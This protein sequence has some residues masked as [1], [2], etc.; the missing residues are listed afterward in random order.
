M[1]KIR[2]RE[3]RLPSENQKRALGELIQYAFVEIR[4]IGSEGKG[5]QASDLADIFHNVSR[6]MFGWG[7]WN[8]DIF[9]GMLQDYQDKYHGESYFGK[10]DY[11]MRFNEI[12]PVT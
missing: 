5:N 10:F 3:I 9:R 6:E 12:Y 7:S 8:P 4:I 2:R 1:F 11:V